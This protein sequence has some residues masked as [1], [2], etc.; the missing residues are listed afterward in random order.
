MNHW[1][2]DNVDNCL[3]CKTMMCNHDYNG[4]YNFGDIVDHHCPK[5]ELVV[6]YQELP[7][8]ETDIEANAEVK[9]IYHFDG[10]PWTEDEIKRI[11]KLKAFL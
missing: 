6:S 2:I 3:I 8:D 5:C 4:I 1:W 11:A 9:I 7:Y 10:K